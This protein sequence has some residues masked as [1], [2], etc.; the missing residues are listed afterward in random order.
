MKPLAIFCV[1]EALAVPAFAQPTVIA[2][3]L[4]A[5]AIGERYD[6]YIAAV[7]V[8]S[9]QV[10]RQIAAVNLRRRNLYIEL[11]ERRRVTPQLVGMATACQLLSQLGVGQAYLLGDGTWHRRAAGQS[12]PLPDYCR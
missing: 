7:G 11:A 5:G 9:P 1:L 8:V 10:Q 2:N 6:G 3:A 4:Q 12:V